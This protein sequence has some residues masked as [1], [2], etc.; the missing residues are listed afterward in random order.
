MIAQMD[1]IASGARVSGNDA[2]GYPRTQGMKD[3][4]HLVNEGGARRHRRL[5]LA[6]L[7]L[8]QAPRPLDPPV[9]ARA[10]RRGQGRL[11]QGRVPDLPWRRRAEAAGD[12]SAHRRHEAGLSRA[13]DEGNARRR[14]AT[15]NRK[16]CCPSP[17]SSTTPA[18]T[19]IADYLSQVVRPAK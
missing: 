17:R 12:L 9:D 10:H 3:I 13:S 8:A 4:M 16:R 15:A 6:S 2:R 11:H 14:R 5:W 19:L 1:D 7:P 18:S